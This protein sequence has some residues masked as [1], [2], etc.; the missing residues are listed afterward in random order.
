MIA[1]F[2]SSVLPLIVLVVA[3]GVLTP[4]GVGVGR[5]KAPLRVTAMPLMTS[6]E[7]GFWRLLRAAAAPLH[8]APQVAM[9]ALL[10]TEFGV[11]GKEWGRT[12]N[13]FDKKVVDYALLDDSGQVRLLVELDNRTHDAGKDRAR[14][15]M[16]ERAGYRTLRVNGVVARDPTLLRAAIDDAL[17]VQRA[18][19]PPTVSP[20]FAPRP[21]RDRSAPPSSPPA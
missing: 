21:P 8:V 19:T 1:G 4:V 10:R 20:L 9:N 12:R 13:Q 15:R 6:R 18:W 14:D 5:S 17:G 3:V 11:R 7:V 16:T 2:G